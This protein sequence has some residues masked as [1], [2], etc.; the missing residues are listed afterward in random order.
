MLL[1]PPVLL[2]LLL[3]LPSENLRRKEEEGTAGTWF[4]DRTMGEARA[5][6]LLYI[7]LAEEAWAP[8]DEEET[9]KEDDAP[10]E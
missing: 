2:P 10:N 4:G 6:T 7:V 8:E 9:E 1:L 3:P 5:E